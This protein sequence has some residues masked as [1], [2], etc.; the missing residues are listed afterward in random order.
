M[1]STGLWKQPSAVATLPNI[2]LLSAGI[3]LTAHY[4]VAYVANSAQ[5]L[6]RASSANFEGH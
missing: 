4:T 3:N 6:G 1:V 5:W 2:I